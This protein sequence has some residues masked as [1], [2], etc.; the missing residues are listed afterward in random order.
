MAVLKD[1]AYGHGDI[2]IAHE[3]EHLGIDFFAVSHIDEAIRLRQNG[4]KSN[5]LIL[6]YTSPHYF[7]LLS[8]YHLTQALIS[9]EY[10]QK[11]DSF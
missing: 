1:N 4:I 11:L 9:L 5:I 3:M 8:K 6:S 10:A 2:T 7:E